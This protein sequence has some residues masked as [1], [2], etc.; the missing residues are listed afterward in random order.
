MR[1]RQLLSWLPMIAM[2]LLSA[3]SSPSVYVGDHSFS[4]TQ[5]AR[6]QYIE[7]RCEHESE[8]S[9]RGMNHCQDAASMDQYRREYSE[10][11]REYE[12]SREQ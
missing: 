6:E 9:P 1:N 12:R 7:N 4:A 5:R 8:R 11:Q 2:V 3:C 10:Y